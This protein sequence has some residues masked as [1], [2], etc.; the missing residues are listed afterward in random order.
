MG[1]EV[2]NSLIYCLFLLFTQSVWDNGIGLL[3]H[4]AVL[5]EFIEE[6]FCFVG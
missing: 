3:H 4:S 1:C 2:R 6:L 5:A